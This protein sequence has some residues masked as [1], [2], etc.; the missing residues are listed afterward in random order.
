LRSSLKP[1]DDIVMITPYRVVMVVVIAAANREAVCEV[2]VIC[3]CCVVIFYQ[4]MLKI[5]KN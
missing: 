1:V 4:D 2:E 5:Q 3:S